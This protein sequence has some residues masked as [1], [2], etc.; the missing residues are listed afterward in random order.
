LRYVQHDFRIEER[1]FGFFPINMATADVIFELLNRVLESLKLD[2]NLMVGQSYDRAA[3]MSGIKNGVAT[4]FKNKIKTAVYVHCHAHKLN[5]AL[6]DASM[7]IRDVI[8]Y[9]IS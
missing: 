6:C 8:R 5:L 2:L 7:Q 3:T 1:F 4:K 9:D